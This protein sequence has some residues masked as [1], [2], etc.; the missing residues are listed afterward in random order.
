[1][2]TGDKIDR[3]IDRSFILARRWRR[4]LA[5]LPAMALTGACVHEVPPPQPPER[6]MPPV[7][8]VP[9]TARPGLAQVIIATDVP[10]RV[11]LRDAYGNDV[12][13]RH[14]GAAAGRLCPTTPCVA[15]LPAGQYALDF[16]GIEDRGRLS[17]S[18]ITVTH[19]T[20][21]VDHTLGRQ[22]ASVAQPI[23]IVLLG[24]GAVLLSWA[25]FDA[26]ASADQ[27]HRDSST[28]AALALTGLGS[29]AVGGVLL[30]VS[31]TTLQRGTT[32]QWTPSP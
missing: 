22:N 10:A 4:R 20:E 15:V 9:Q 24:V 5:L 18:W 6:T 32:T 13:S 25:A 17:S 11:G 23:G 2:R 12:P 14:E 3:S 27:S 1:M 30:G 31:P 19:D 16:W 8:S 7:A 29:A 26:V 21:V 28:D